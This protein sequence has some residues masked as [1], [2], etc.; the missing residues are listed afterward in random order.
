MYASLRETKTKSDYLYKKLFIFFIAIELIAYF[1]NDDTF[2]QLSGFYLPLLAALAFGIPLLF[3]EHYDTFQLCELLMLLLLLINSLIN[4][5]NLERG[6]ILSYIIGLLLLMELSSIK[7]DKKLIDKLLL[8]YILAAFIMAL[9]IIIFRHRYYENVSNRLTIKIGDNTVI[10]PN[11]LASFMVV[12]CLLA[13]NKVLKSKSNYRLINLLIFTVIALG[14]T[15]TGS[16]GAFVSSAVSV[17]F[18][19]LAM[20]KHKIKCLLLI[21]VVF[22]SSAVILYM[23]TSSD[24]IIRFLDVRTWFD[25]SNSR[26]LRL[27]R[28]AF[29]A[30][31]QNPIIGYGA[32]GSEKIIGGVMGDYEPAH[33]T[34]IEIWV[35]EGILFLGCLAVFFICIFKSKKSL[36]AKS[37]CIAT[38]VSSIFISAEATIWFWL[39][40]GLSVLLIRNRS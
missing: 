13:F 26:R 33:N 34:F 31:G 7:L 29:I 21:L 30:I 20:S 23:T 25:S 3:N 38:A 36:L 22:I 17:V 11:Y 5:A 15:L 4:F 1:L 32:E 2:F 8:C 37:I 16:R 9:L 14:I 40:M 18:M 35:Q 10:D 27:W 24:N 28:N 39:N 12:P 6:Y 19:T